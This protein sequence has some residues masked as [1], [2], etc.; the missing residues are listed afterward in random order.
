MNSNIEELNNKINSIFSMLDYEINDEEK[1]NICKNY[2]NCL[3]DNKQALN[4]MID[5]NNNTFNLVK[6]FNNKFDETINLLSDNDD[7]WINL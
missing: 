1:F 4:L 6:I 3:K 5:R 7:F 2:I